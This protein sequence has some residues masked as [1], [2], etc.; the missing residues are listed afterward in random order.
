MG[1]YLGAIPHR[2]K[3]SEL[4]PCAGLSGSPAFNWSSLAWSILNVPFRM[5]SGTD[6]LNKR[7]LRVSTP[8]SSLLNAERKV[9]RSQP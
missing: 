6:V 4:K 2:F 7:V 9:A 5:S 1:A 8:G 3:H